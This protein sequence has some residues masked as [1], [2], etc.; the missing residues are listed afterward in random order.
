MSLRFELK[1]LELRLEELPLFIEV[2]FIFIYPFFILLPSL[3]LFL[4]EFQFTV[5]PLLSNLI[6]FVF[7]GYLE[8]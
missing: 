2:L 5:L 1:L 7:V 6:L 4:L 3:L 8:L